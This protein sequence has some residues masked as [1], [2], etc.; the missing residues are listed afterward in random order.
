M[1]RNYHMKAKTSHKLGQKETAKKI[2]ELMTHG[3]PAGGAGMVGQ[4][5]KGQGKGKRWEGD[6]QQDKFE[7]ESTHFVG[8]AGGLCI[9]SYRRQLPTVF[10]VI[11]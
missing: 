9:A 5:G 4:T 8:G 7:V 2:E 11:A 1:R 3:S 10:E 6:K